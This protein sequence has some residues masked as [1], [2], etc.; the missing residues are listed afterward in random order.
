MLNVPLPGSGSPD[1]DELA[2]ISDFT[3]WMNVN[4]RAIYGTRPWSVYGEGPSTLSVAALRE[5]GFNEGRNKPYTAEDLRFVQKDGKVYAF[6]LAWPESKRLTIKSLAEGSAH[7][8]GKIERVELLG[9][10]K[11]LEFTRDAQGLNLTLPDGRSSGYAFTF[12]YVF[13]FEISGTGITKG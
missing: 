2:F 5:Q 10:P 1:D 3:R 4:G 7:A 6:A 9:S 13:S 8:P 11:P 12:D